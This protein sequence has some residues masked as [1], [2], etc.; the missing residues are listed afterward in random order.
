MS[1]K[2]WNDQLVAFHSAYPGVTSDLLA[3]LRTADGETS[4]EML[5]RRIK[6][7][8]PEARDILDVGCGDGTLLACLAQ[9]YGRD[10]RLCGID[11]SAAE[12]A[13]ARAR[14]PQAQLVRGD[15]SSA[16]MRENSYDVVTSHLAFMAMPALRTVLQRAH[17]ALRDGGLLAF[18]IEDPLAG[19]AIFQLMGGAVAAARERREAFAPETPGR[20][21]VEHDDVLR[22]LLR[23]AGFSTTS[24]ERFTVRGKL[25][26]A[27]LWQ[28][29]E[30]SY[31]F[32]LLDSEF[33]GD[34]RA[35]TRAQRLAIADAP[36]PAA[37]SLR[38]IV[39]RT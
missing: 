30:R 24:I 8:A 23:A 15:A 12:L 29:V 4:Y 16:D 21:A 18:V 36:A 9:L 27:Q 31:P 22:E 10:V 13:H 35:A 19:G 39:A 7:S 38:L 26:S 20:E 5:A 28:F 34:V 11:L 33:L 14:V 37:F 3:P 25:S 17:R 6:A 2:D 1:P 32:G